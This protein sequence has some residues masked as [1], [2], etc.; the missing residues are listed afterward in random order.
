VTSAGQV[1]GMHKTIL[2]LI[3][4]CSNREHKNEARYR[5]LSAS[6]VRADGELLAMAKNKL[7]AVLDHEM[8]S[9]KARSYVE[10]LLN[11]ATSTAEAQADSILR[12]NPAYCQ[13]LLSGER[14]NIAVRSPKEAMIIIN[15]KIGHEWTE[16]G[17][18]YRVFF[19]VRPKLAQRTING[20]AVTIAS[21]SGAGTRPY[22]RAAFIQQLDP[23]GQDSGAV[24]TAIRDTLISEG[25][26]DLQFEEEDTPLGKK[27]IIKGLVE[28]VGII[29]KQE[30]L[31]YIG[32]KGAIELTSVDV[33]D[34]P[35]LAIKREFY[36]SLAKEAN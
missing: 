34:N 28:R 16:K 21:T 3:S 23:T 12:D 24:I 6:L 17:C 29:L 26:K 35:Y 33:A 15:F 30:T 5:A 4:R 22:L 27:I 1:S 14:W 18:G 36:D 13:R 25:L 8:G 10:G 20:K 7:V 19:P 11:T 31:I 32:N 9:D 2:A